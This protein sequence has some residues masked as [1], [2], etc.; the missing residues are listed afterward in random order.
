MST[1]STGFLFASPVLFLIRID[2]R[3]AVLAANTVEKVLLALVDTRKQVECLQ[4]RM[5]AHDDDFYLV[6]MNWFCW[7]EFKKTTPGFT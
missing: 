7:Y 2:Q 6:T 1:G 3:K 5:S 4:L